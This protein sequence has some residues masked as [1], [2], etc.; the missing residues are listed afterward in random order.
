MLCFIEFLGVVYLI[1]SYLKWFI[2][3]WSLDYF[4]DI[5]KVFFNFIKVLKNVF[6]CE[7]VYRGKIFIFLDLMFYFCICICVYVILVYVIL[8]EMGIF[9]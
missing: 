8:G 3:Y 1:R 6:K 5:E 7:I 9:V 4:K 2:Y